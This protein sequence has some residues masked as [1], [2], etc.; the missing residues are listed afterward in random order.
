MMLSS[1]ETIHLRPVWAVAKI[2][3]ERVLQYITINKESN[4]TDKFHTIAKTYGVHKGV[5]KNL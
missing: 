1:S 2:Y 4:F 3:N 5:L